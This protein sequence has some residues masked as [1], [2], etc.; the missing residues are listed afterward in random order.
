MKK[1]E[2]KHRRLYAFYNSTVLNALVI[3]GIVSIML[4]PLLQPHELPAICG[5][6]AFALFIGYSLWL[7]LQKPKRIEICPGLS[8]T[9]GLFVLYFLIVTAIS[10]ENTWWYGIP[11]IAA[12]VT[13][14]IYMLSP[15]KELFD[16]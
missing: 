13:L 6:L 12:V 3:I 4:M 2:I 8:D 10:P 7:W 9:G 15:K 5:A 11:A 16:I 1:L 14:F